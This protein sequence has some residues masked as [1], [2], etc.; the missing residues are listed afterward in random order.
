[1]TARPLSR[2]KILVVDDNPLLR[3]GLKET[4]ALWGANRVVVAAD[5]AEA[6]AVLRREPMDV[7]LTDWMM[8]P[9]GGA[10][11]V[12]WVRCAPE[13]P[14]PD[15][16]ILVLT[17]RADV[18]TV[19]CAWDA[20]VD[21]VLAK[22]LAATEI[23]RRIETVLTRPRRR[24]AATA[25]PPPPEDRGAEPM[26]LPPPGSMAPDDR[27]RRLR[28]LV[29][30]DGLEAEADSPYPEA[31]RLRD[32]VA[33]VHRTAAGDPALAELAASLLACVVDVAPGGH[34]YVEA[35]RAHL[36]A[37][38]WMLAHGGGTDAAR[39]M[40]ECLRATVRALAPPP[41]ARRLTRPGITF[42]TANP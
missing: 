18:P 19:R 13:S 23:V 42:G 7:L 35:V 14:R 16:P 36:A 5:G 3:R 29:A 20:G 9:V 27:Q 38:R 2:L 28:L 37:F 25:S 34:G 1:M 11:L 41:H 40:L 17:A 21:A 26:R 22:P 39:S 10:A 33:D 31:D 12:R 6:Q 15:L 24:P 30:L 4:F 8:E 32:A